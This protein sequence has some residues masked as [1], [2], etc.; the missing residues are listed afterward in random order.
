MHPGDLIRDKAAD[1]HFDGEVSEL[2]IRIAATVEELVELAR[3]VGRL[4]V[5]R[6]RMDDQ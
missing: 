2:L 4:S 3:E 5:L 1:L 6:R